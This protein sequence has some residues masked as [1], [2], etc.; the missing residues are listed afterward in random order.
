MIEFRKASYKILTPVYANEIYPLIE[1]VGRLA[2][3]S[4]DLI[5]TD[6]AEKFVRMLVDR[7]HLSVLE[8]FSF[9]VQF[10]I[11]RGISHELVRHRLASFTQES[12]RYCNYSKSK[13]GNKIVFI[14]PN[15][16]PDELIIDYSDSESW[17]TA[18]MHDFEDKLKPEHFMFITQM[19]NSAEAYFSLLDSGWLP[20][21]ARAVLPNALKTEIVVTANLREWMHILKLRT[22]K[23]AH[24]QIREVM[25]PLLKELQQE[26]PAIF[27]T[28]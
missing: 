9:S 22:S 2:Y 8:H 17:Q 5:T 21:Q 3:K 25:E 18:L 14:L 26:L 1:K 6:S 13:F 23:A 20:Q 27:G 12:T 11:D 24:P 15:W 28:I 16:L 7:G 4:E 10:V 19:I